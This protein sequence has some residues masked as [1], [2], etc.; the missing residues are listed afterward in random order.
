MLCPYISGG[1]SLLL[2]FF[3]PFLQVRKQIPLKMIT[4]LDFAFSLF[5]LLVLIWISKMEKADAGTVDEDIVTAADYT[6]CLP[7]LPAGI[8]ADEMKPALKE[9][10]EKYLPGH[11]QIGKLDINRA[12]QDMAE[13]AKN[14]VAVAEGVAAK[15]HETADAAKKT[16]DTAKETADAAKEKLDKADKESDEHKTLEAEY[17]KLEA[18]HKKLGTEY[19]KL[20][21]VAKAADDA[22]EAAKE[23]EKTTAA[24]GDEVT[25]DQL[26]RVRNIAFGFYN[27]AVI[28][29]LAKRGKLIRY[30]E[31]VQERLYLNKTIG[32]VKKVLKNEKVMRK[33]NK[34]V[35]KYEKRLDKMEESGKY[36][37]NP[38]SAFVTFEREE[39]YLR[40]VDAYPD[41]IFY[42]LCMRKKLKMEDKR[43][44]KHYRLDIE[45]AKE[46]TDI[47]WENLDKTANSRRLRTC[48]VCC[49]ALIL[50]VCGTIFV[51][52]AKVSKNAEFKMF[53]KID[54]PSF[55]EVMSDKQGQFFGNYTANASTSPRVAAEHAK[56]NTTGF[57]RAFVEQMGNYSFLDSGNY[58]NSKEQVNVVG[59]FCEKGFT[60]NPVQVL[61]R[62]PPYQ[63]FNDSRM[64]ANGFD[65]DKLC[66]GY[67]AA[68]PAFIDGM[69]GGYE[70]WKA[71]TG[72]TYTSTA[73]GETEKIEP[74]AT[75]P[76]TKGW[77]DDWVK[78]QLYLQT[79]NVVSI[80]AV[81]LV[82]TIL[83][84]AM[85]VMTVF[86]RYPSRTQY[87]QSIFLKVF[88]V[89]FINIGL[90]NVLVNAN[91]ELLQRG[92]SSFGNM[93]AGFQDLFS[94]N[95][96]SF[97]M[98]NG[99]YRDLDTR[100]YKDVGSTF[101]M[102]V[103]LNSAIPVFTPLL[104]MV[105][106]YLKR[107]MNRGCSRNLRKS[108]SETQADLEKLYVGP[109]FNLAL[110]YSST[111][112]YI[113]IT[114]FL[115]SGMPVLVPI[116]A[117]LLFCRFWLDKLYLFK[118]HRTPL[119]YVQSSGAVQLSSVIVIKT[120][121]S[122]K[123]LHC[124]GSRIF[125]HI[126]AY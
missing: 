2:P 44:G 39:G 34:R 95:V 121:A 103:G 114:L 11:R 68:N 100:W 59:C 20:V 27:S 56:Y 57:T 7:T 1:D 113:T 53:P 86:Q 80:I 63:D 122:R 119:M 106:G 67:G 16:A 40:A 104:F 62:L 82:N 107:C 70:Q 35:D 75:C 115:C 36:V 12:S 69:F 120:F 88:I 71:P 125:P 85:I 93:V 19:E 117:I 46:A 111:V 91:L 72:A 98:L 33:Y 66:F 51:V 25:V 52:A 61:E 32:N 55:E 14:A 105:L 28:D 21:V 124:T 42:Y 123:L 41:G 99:D 29:L 110:A 8:D 81:T 108:K 78:R 112:T 3:L 92:D 89:Q 126:P 74:S 37:D 50:I 65:R 6:I 22:L 30:M 94:L 31:K 9:H 38:V 101:V 73:S 49:T 54:C 79:W 24:L 47:L 18:A 60:T 87:E 84:K 4:M 96:P 116:M 5:F 10:F 102:T 58:L 23:A 48:A 17:K 26:C 97:R 64:Y 77:C 76:T 13:S 90:V 43:T 83:K 118:Y 15:A 45:Q 109:P